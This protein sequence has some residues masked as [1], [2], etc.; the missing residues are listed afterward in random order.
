MHSGG[1]FFIN[2]VSKA[3]CLV[4]PNDQLSGRARNGFFEA[5]SG[6]SELQ[7]RVGLRLVGGYEFRWNMLIELVVL[8]EA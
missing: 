5:T 7:R 8:I 4:G 1:L 6:F 2:D 3:W